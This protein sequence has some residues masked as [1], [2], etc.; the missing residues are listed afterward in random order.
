M[1]NPERK[2]L[3]WLA[4]AALGWA[5]IAQSFAG[6]RRLDEDWA[7]AALG[8]GG[9][10]L[11]PFGTVYAVWA[12]MLW[13]GRSR[14]R[15]GHRLLG[16]WH[17]S[18]D[19]WRRFTRFDPIRATSGEGLANDFNPARQDSSRGIDV[20]IGETGVAIGDYYQ[21]LRRGGIPGLRALYWLPEPADPQC[22]EFHVI[23]PRRHGGGAPVC[24]RVPI[25]SSAHGEARLA[26]D[27]FAP[28]LAPREA[29][30]LRNP[31]RTIRIALVVVVVSALGAAWGIARGGG[32]D[33]SSIAT[34][35][36]GVISAIV[37]L[38]ALAIAIATWMVS[39]PKG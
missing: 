10:I 23:Y 20:L 7:V 27:H 1:R 12:L 36:A 3:I 32:N 37:G 15:G 2:M 29:L 33:S 5:A 25:A 31:A 4:L 21:V 30:A 38:T 39:R 9:A 8:I 18:E 35:I 28:L 34:L 11:I 16:R 19:E 6:S 24:V 13:R 26:F 14:L 22:L 17:L